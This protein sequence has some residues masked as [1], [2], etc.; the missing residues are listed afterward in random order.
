MCLYQKTF[1]HKKIK[2]QDFLCNNNLKISLN[3]AQ[4]GNGFVL[5]PLTMLS[6]DLDVLDSIYKNKYDLMKDIFFKVYP[7]SSSLTEVMHCSSEQSTA[8]F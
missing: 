5:L 1:P 7:S 8:R 3:C 2:L 4:Y 6:H